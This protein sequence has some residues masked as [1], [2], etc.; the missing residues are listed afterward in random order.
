MPDG[1][2]VAVKKFSQAKTQGHRQFTA[3]METLGK[4]K[5]QNLVLL[6]GYCSFDEEKLL[7]YEYMVKGSLDDW[8]RNRVASLDWGKRF[9]IVCGVAHGITFLHQGF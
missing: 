1:K 7:V 4:V 5:H 6:L 8:L 2:T 9:K 3:E